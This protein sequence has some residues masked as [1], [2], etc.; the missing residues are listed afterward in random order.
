MGEITLEE[1]IGFSEAFDYYKLL[2]EDEQKRIPEAFVNDMKKYAD[3]K[4][5]GKIL[6]IDDIN[7]KNVSKDGA[8]KITFMSLYE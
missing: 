2:S 4:Y 8:K 6:T 7:T 1:V 3:E 5:I